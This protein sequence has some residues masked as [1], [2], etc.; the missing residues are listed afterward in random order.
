MVA[1]M[2]HA[3]EPSSAPV[4][5]GDYRLDPAHASLIFKVS[6]LGFSMYTARF[7]DFDAR[8]YFDPRQLEAAKLQARV[9][10]RSLETDFPNPKQLD[11]N[12]QL[13]GEEWLATEKHPQIRFVSTDV[14]MTGDREMQVTG[15]FTLRGVTRPLTLNVRYN[16]GYAGHEIDPNARVGFSATGTV[17]RA[18]YGMD[19]GLPPAGSN[20]GVGN[21]VQVIIEAEFTGPPLPQ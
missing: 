21:D 5:A 16:G 13:Q 1:R 17:K 10:A 18:D 8:L 2:T 3:Q 6:H 12:A 19:F 20:M 4:P 9:D 15:D 7:T 14:K 11:F